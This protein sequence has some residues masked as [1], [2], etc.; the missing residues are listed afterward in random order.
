VH[1]RPE[2]ESAQG[3]GFGS[4]RRFAARTEGRNRH[5]E[6]RMFGRMIQRFLPLMALLFV[7]FAGERSAHAGKGFLLITTGDE[8]RKVADLKPEF[9]E[10][11]DQEL[12]P[13]IEVG[14]KYQHFGLFFLEV[15][16]WDGKY[17][18]FRDDEYWDPPEAEVAEMAGVS[19]VNDLGKPWQYTFKPGLL[20]IVVLIGGFVAFKMLTKDKDEGGGEGEAAET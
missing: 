5:D 18:L 12:G 8:I 17:V 6:R 10:M 9:K 11:A 15:W 3:F 2:H 20:I 1:S 7:C 4:G 16:A 14:Y 19:S 13:G